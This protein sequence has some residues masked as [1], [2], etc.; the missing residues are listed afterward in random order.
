MWVNHKNATFYTTVFVVVV[1]DDFDTCS[2]FQPL[3]FKKYFV[4]NFLIKVFNHFSHTTAFK[5]RPLIF[6]ICNVDQYQFNFEC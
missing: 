5:K 1:I 6:E 4:I 2:I 3:I